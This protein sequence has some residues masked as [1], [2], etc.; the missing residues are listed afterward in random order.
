MS[1]FPSSS[2][3]SHASSAIDSSISQDDTGGREANE[4][5]LFASLG[6]LHRSKGKEDATELDEK[7]K[8]ETKGRRSFAPG[9]KKKPLKF[10]D[11]VGRKFSFPFHLCATWEGKCT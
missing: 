10:K 11:A 2:S 9:E 6:R 4:R 5:R 1:S 7:D 8:E 3:R